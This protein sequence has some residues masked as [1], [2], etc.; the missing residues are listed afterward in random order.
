MKMSKGWTHAVGP[1]HMHDVWRIRLVRQHGSDSSSEAGWLGLTESK[2]SSRRCNPPHMIININ[3]A[4][5][6]HLC[7]DTSKAGAVHDSLSLIQGPSWNRG[8]AEQME[9]TIQQAAETLQPQ[10]TAD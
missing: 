7:G 10:E 2:V 6:T 3:T 4:W 9:Q 5:E 8:W 1:M